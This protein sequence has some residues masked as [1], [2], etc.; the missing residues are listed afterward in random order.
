MAHS[1]GPWRIEGIGSIDGSGVSHYHIR[2]ADDWR[3]VATVW[4][5]V[6]DGKVRGCVLKDNAELVAKAPE[7]KDALAQQIANMQMLLNE[8]ELGITVDTRERLKREL[9]LATRIIER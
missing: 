6:V 5:N 4:R 3:P 7:M 9:E 8:C 1:L 2:P